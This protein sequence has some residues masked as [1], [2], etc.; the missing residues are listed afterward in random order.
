MSIAITLT[1]LL[2]IL[3]E[4][5]SSRIETQKGNRDLIKVIILEVVL[6]FGLPLLPPTTNILFLSFEIL[7]VIGAE[8]FSLFLFWKAFAIELTELFIFIGLSMKL[9]PQIISRQ[10]S[11]LFSK[12]KAGRVRIPDSHVLNLF[13]IKKTKHS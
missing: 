4:R 11:H 5:F 10:A 9:L 12:I 2:V 6:L 7:L 8:C 13:S 1:L 3:T